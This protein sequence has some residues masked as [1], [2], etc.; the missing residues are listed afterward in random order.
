MGVFVELNF[1]DGFS[2]ISQKLQKIDFIILDIDLPAAYSLDGLN[3]EVLGLLS[4][5]EN[6]QKHPDET[7]DEALL[8]KACDQLKK[9]A[10]FYLYTKL[11]VELG[12]PK[13]HILFCSNHGENTQTI[14]EA[15]KSAKIALP[16]I[17]QKSDSDVQSWVKNRYENQYS[18]LR[19]GII[20]GCH[21]AKNLSIDKLYFNQFTNNNESIQTEDILNYFEVLED[22]LPLREPENKKSLYKLFIRTLSSE[23]EAAK[24]IKRDNDK[25]DAVLAWI[26]RNTRHWITHNS[27]LFNE[28]DECLVA[29]LFIVNMRVMFNSDDNTLQNYEE[30]LLKLFY[31][32]SLSDADFKSKDIPASKAYLELKNIILDENENKNHKDKIEDAFYFNELANNIQLSNSKLRND[33]K[34]FIKLL[35]QLF[36]LTTSN[37]FIETKSRKNLLEIKFSNFKYTDYM[38]ELARHIYHRSFP[39]GEQP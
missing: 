11:V 34:L 13:Q 5:F 18:R 33:K 16:K 38:S 28:V 26:M 19:R 2:F 9:I 20:E 12:F 3:A 14:Q 30:I 27:N 4:N 24:N 36:W 37:P 10:G 39:Q 17:H 32:E 7:E 15:F 22:F 29:Y 1:Q 6:Y 23:W 35:Y 31:R 25:K 8:K 21:Q